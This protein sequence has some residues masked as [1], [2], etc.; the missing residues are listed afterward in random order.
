MHE[1]N[2]VWQRELCGGKELHIVVITKNDCH[3]EGYHGI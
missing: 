3:A 1:A 2:V